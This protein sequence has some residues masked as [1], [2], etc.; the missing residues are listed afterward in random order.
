MLA[1]KRELRV[2][3]RELAITEA[4]GQGNLA[5]RFLRNF[6]AEV[7]CIGGAGRDQPY[8]HDGARSPGV[9]LVDGIA[10]GV[11]LERAVEVRTLFDRALAVILDHAAP[12]DRLAFVVDTFQLE[13]GIVG[14]D[15]AAGKE[16]SDSLG[17]HHDIDANG[18]AETD[19]G[20]H[21][22]Q[23]RGDGSS[24]GRSAGRDFCFRF[25]SHGEGGGKL[26]LRHGSG[27]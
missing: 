24:L 3:I 12:E 8:V 27:S 26:M 6:H 10:M 5:A 15:G 11:H 4:G 1:R 9:A 25:F 19:G 17:T 7:H 23:R 22:V 20:L 14:I 16:M 2:E 18:V 13:P 21:A